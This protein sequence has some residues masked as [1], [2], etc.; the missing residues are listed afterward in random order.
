MDCPCDTDIDGVMAS[1]A[2]KDVHEKNN[3]ESPCTSTPCPDPHRV[4]GLDI[5]AVLHK[6]R[7]HGRMPE[8]T[9][10]VQRRALVLASR[11]RG[12]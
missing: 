2:I 8:D 11:E 3:T 1:L 10:V 5:G 7:R 6:L 9:R 12:E 4:D